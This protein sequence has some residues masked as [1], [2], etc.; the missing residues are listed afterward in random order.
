MSTV[1]TRGNTAFFTV[2]CL[3]GETHK[4]TI[5]TDGVI[6]N[7]HHDAE[8]DAVILA[9]G[10]QAH[11]C[12][13]TTVAYRAA[14]E[15]FDAENGIRDVPGLRYHNYRWRD[16]GTD[17]CPT[18]GC[19]PSI[20]HISSVKHRSVTLGA[21]I[22]AARTLF[23]WL[24]RNNGIE[25]TVSARRV[26]RRAELIALLSE[27][28]LPPNGANQFL[29]NLIT[30]AY[31]GAALKI[32]PD[33]THMS[34]RDRHQEIL[35]LR[36]GGITLDWIRTFAEH[37]SPGAVQN[38]MQAGRTYYKSL[39]HARNVDPIKVA[40]LNNAGIV[41]HFYTYVKAGA[42]PEQVLKVYKATN[43]TTALADLLNEGLSIPQA[44][45]RVTGSPV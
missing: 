6:T 34:V 29:S 45:T 32:V 21:D 17:R 4:F 18:G 33:S 38:G 12:G 14:R 15:S 16:G 25:S 10:G 1:R 43:R 9:L 37:V 8:D 24:L 19:G 36:N 3:D 39:K 5:T 11:P 28:G 26:E 27:H 22:T 23:N 42:T 35:D 40:R 31:L 30:P 20:D 13:L 7:P 44:I 2:P 41:S